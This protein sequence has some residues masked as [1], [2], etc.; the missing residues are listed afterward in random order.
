MGFLAQVHIYC[1]LMSYL[2]SLGCEV[3]QVLRRPF[4][5]LRVVLVT[6]TVAGFV[7]HT[8]FLFTRSRN[9]G[10]PPLLTSQQDWLL[11]LAWLGSLLYL[12]LLVS[13]RQMAHGIFMLPAILLLVIV[14]LFASPVASGNLHEQVMRRWGMFHAAS[15]VLGIGAVAGAALSGLM[16]LLHYQRL[17]TRSAWLTKLALPSLENLSAIN[18]WMVVFSVPC[19]TIGLLTGF[20]LISFSKAQNA[21][22]TIPW[23]DPTIV[24]T[25]LVWLAMIVVLVRLLMNT[26]QTGRAVAQLS[27]LS[28]GFLLLTVLGPMLLAG[29][30]S[31]N[32]IHG[33]PQA[34]AEVPDKAAADAVNDPAGTADAAAK[35]AST[36]GDAKTQEPGR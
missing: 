20:L 26:Q 30:G 2:V 27:F 35:N 31:F 19:L 13:H 14:A 5:I 36:S 12:I 18:R 15:L 28:G 8:A 32:A 34:P 11:V 17:K 9:E 22:Y 3:L 10:L 23:T 1:F 25:I 24:T 7:A 16:Y 21:T 29:Q 6:F 4:P 33:R